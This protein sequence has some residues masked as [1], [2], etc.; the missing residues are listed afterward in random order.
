MVRF[1]ASSRSFADNFHFVHG[2]VGSR[3]SPRGVLGAHCPL[4]QSQIPGAQFSSKGKGKG[5]VSEG[6]R[7]GNWNEEW[8]SLTYMQRLLACS[9]WVHH[10]LCKLKVLLTSG[11]LTS[12]CIRG[13]GVP[14]I[15]ITNVG[16]L[17][18]DGSS[19]SFWAQ[20]RFHGVRESSCTSKRK[21]TSHSS[22][23]PKKNLGIVCSL[24]DLFF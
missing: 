20:P 3:A 19:F 9:R 5:K 10:K 11:T 22:D 24:E 8:S 7:W 14:Y 17:S 23:I 18:A 6:D 4:G 16:R 15:P 21:G 13:I 12:K 2:S 1:C